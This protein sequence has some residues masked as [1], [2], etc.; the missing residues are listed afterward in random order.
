MGFLGN[1]GT[2]ELIIIALVLLF[3]FGG[4]KLTEL[5]RGAGETGRE[6]K[7]VKKEFQETLNETPPESKGA[8]DNTQ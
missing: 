2:P 4:K 7:K 5:A 6:L 8:E 1:I 3:F